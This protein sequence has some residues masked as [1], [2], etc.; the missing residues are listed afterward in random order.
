MTVE[1]KRRDARSSTQLHEVKTM[2][3]TPVSRRHLLKGAGIAGAAG[4]AALAPG[5]L[6]AKAD[7]KEDSIVGTWLGTATLPGTPPFGTLLAF[8]AGGTLSHSTAV[9]LQSSQLSS[10]S[11]GAWKRT[12]AGKYAVKF[13]FFTFDAQTN[14]SGSGEVTEKLTVDGDNLHGPIDVKVFDTTGA[15]VFASPG[16]ITAKRIEVG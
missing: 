16:S 15:V 1:R 11:Y 12:D 10:P 2:A 14:P 8:A 9:D 4:L 5:A 6:I 7:T 13:F 3:T